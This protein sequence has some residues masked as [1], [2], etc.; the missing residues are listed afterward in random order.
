MPG[1]VTM[2]R[3]A[4]CIGIGGLANETA[5]EVLRAFNRPDKERTYDAQAAMKMCRFVEACSVSEV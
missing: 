2:R 4:L 5:L 1:R 3:V